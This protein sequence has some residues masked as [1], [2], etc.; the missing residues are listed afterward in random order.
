MLKSGIGRSYRQ[1][2]AP[3]GLPVSLTYLPSC[4]PITHRPPPLT[5]S[6]SHGGQ[7]WTLSKHGLL[8]N[9]MPKYERFGGREAAGAGGPVHRRHRLRACG[10]LRTAREK[11]VTRLRRWKDGFLRFHHPAELNPAVGGRFGVCKVPKYGGR[12]HVDSL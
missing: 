6:R 5:S 3:H 7:I 4:R 1:Q 12:M 11:E 10:A 2:L 9:N 8:A